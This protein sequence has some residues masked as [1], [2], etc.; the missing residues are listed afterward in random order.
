MLLS[1]T[2]RG[3]TS[4]LTS[5]S[6][7][8]QSLCASSSTMLAELQE[9]MLCCGYLSF[10]W[11]SP[12]SFY[13]RFGQLWLSVIVSC[14]YKRSFLFW[15]CAMCGG[16]CR[17][18]GWVGSQSGRNGDGLTR[19]PLVFSF[20]LFCSANYKGFRKFFSNNRNLERRT[21]IYLLLFQNIM[22]YYRIFIKGK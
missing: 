7:G 2:G 9:Q 20:H 22:L 13:L 11:G 3:T 21:N 8:S 5:W 10:G 19:N 15:V 18:Q 1:V 17:R 6:S 16:S 14:C 12:G 4:Q